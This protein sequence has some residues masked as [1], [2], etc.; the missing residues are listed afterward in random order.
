MSLDLRRR[1]QPSHVA[2][3]NAYAHL[4]LEQKLFAPGSLC[5]LQNDMSVANASGATVRADINSAL[6]SL[7]GLSSGATAPSTAYAYQLWAD[8]T[9]NTLKRRNAANSAWIVVRTLDETFVLSRSSNT[10]LDI[11]DTGKVIRATSTFTQTIDAAATIG[12]G[13]FC[14]YQN[15]GTGV[16]TIDPNSSETIDGSTTI[17]LNPGEGCFISC[18]G[19]SFTTIGLGLVRGSSTVFDNLT[20]SCSVG[21]NALTIALKT[22]NG[23]DPTAANPIRIPIRSVTP[24]NGDYSELLLTAATS[25][26]LSN[27]STLGTIASTANRIWI[28]GF[29]DAGTFRLG[30]INCLS[31]TAP[32][33]NVFPLGAWGIAS[34]TAEGGA[35]AADSAHVFYTGTAVS[36]KAYRVLGYLTYES[37]LGTAGVYASA[38]T[39]VEV[40]GPGVKLPGDIVQR[41]REQTGAV[42]TGTTQIPHDDTIP[43]NTEGDEYIDVDITPTSAANLLDISGQ[44]IGANTGTTTSQT[45]ALFQD[46]TANALAASA[47]IPGGGGNAITEHGVSHRMRA[48]TTSSTQ[49]NLRVGTSAAGTTTFNGVSSA[50]TLGGA[51]ASFLSVEEVMV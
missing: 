37:G 31:G 29:N 25:L 6:Q 23:D 49:I 43:Q 12:D 10:V 22:R 32:N 46:S 28:V 26:V 47:N 41:V 13:W 34:S 21:A 24:A 42:A 1:R 38:P 16:I 7:A 45:A 3:G 18:N 33:F 2:R 11:S 9:T 39:R 30:A 35:G 4:E 8:T 51:H 36:A 44:F 19:T 27:G 48:G 14:W 40:F 17:K 15:A 5:F 20:I 50:R